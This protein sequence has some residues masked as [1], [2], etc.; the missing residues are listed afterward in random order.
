MRTGQVSAQWSSAVHAESQAV[1]AKQAV[2]CCLLLAVVALGALGAVYCKREGLSH[3][4]IALLAGAGV[5]VFVGL[6]CL[7]CRRAVEAGPQPPPG[8]Q[9]PTSVRAPADPGVRRR[10]EPFWTE[11]M[12]P[13]LGPQVAAAER[14]QSRNFDW[15]AATVALVENAENWVHYPRLANILFGVDRTS[16]SHRREEMTALQRIKVSI[17]RAAVNPQAAERFIQGACAYLAP[18]YLA[19][20]PDRQRQHEAVLADMAA[21]E[22][23][24]YPLGIH[25]INGHMAEALDGIEGARAQTT[26]ALEQLE[27]FY[28]VGAHQ[29]NWVLT[30]HAGAPLPIESAFTINAVAFLMERSNWAL[31]HGGVELV[32]LETAVETYL[33]LWARNW[34][35]A[36]FEALTSRVRGR[37]QPGLLQ[38]LINHWYADLLRMSVHRRRRQEPFLQMTRSLGLAPPTAPAVTP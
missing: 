15:D 22:Q 35:E 8:R 3:R 38:P 36:E 4:T 13:V 24:L 25:L 10:P 23:D 29:G 37:V 28:D 17:E 2:G 33:V 1:T 20:S 31:A 12:G 18:R 7:M 11:L 19:I 26:H 32:P 14:G 27:L 5:T 34:R 30:G 9:P 16:A 6:G 21:T